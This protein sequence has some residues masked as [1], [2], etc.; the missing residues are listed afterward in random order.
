MWFKKGPMSKFHAVDLGNGKTLFESDEYR[1][2]HERRK[3]E[4]TARTQLRERLGIRLDNIEANAK[5]L[6]DMM[7]TNGCFGETTYD[8]SVIFIPAA[9]KF[10]LEPEHVMVLI[11]DLIKRKKISFHYNPH[12]LGDPREILDMWNVMKC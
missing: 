6:F 3:V 10:G 12:H 11:D 7:E 8:P 1:R 4:R 9:S 5:L 2:D